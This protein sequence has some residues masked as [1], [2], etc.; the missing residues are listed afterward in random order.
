MYAECART[1][2]IHK[3]LKYGASKKPRECFEMFGFWNTGRIQEADQT[4]I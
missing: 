3:P 2:A 4:D 1:Q